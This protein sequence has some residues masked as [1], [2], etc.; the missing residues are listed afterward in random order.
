MRVYFGAEAER[1]VGDGVDGVPEEGASC[2]VGSGT[3]RT[4]VRGERAPPVI[5]EDF[6][7]VVGVAAGPG[8]S[9]GVAG[10]GRRREVVG[11]KAEGGWIVRAEGGYGGVHLARGRSGK[12]EEGMERGDGASRGGMKEGVGRLVAERKGE[13]VSEIGEE[14]GAGREGGHE[15]E[16]F[17]R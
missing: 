12:E 15:E 6:L 7:A 17:G 5:G 11:V 10:A 4:G 16:R 14:G 3:G 2:A 13:V 8:R 9:E 1:E